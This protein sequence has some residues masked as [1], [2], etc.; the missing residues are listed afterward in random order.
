MDPRVVLPA[1]VQEGREVL[2]AGFVEQPPQIIFG[3]DPVWGLED[4][5]AVIWMLSTPEIY[6][7]AQVFVPYSKQI[8][9]A[10]NE[11]YPI[12]TNFTDC[13]NTRHHTWLKWLGAKFIRRVDSFGAESR[14]FYE[15]VSYRPSCA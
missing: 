13:R 14:P 4:E 10:Y 3:V 1:Y 6:K 7:H 11:R 15:F 12:L 2:V 8:W 5:A 9:D